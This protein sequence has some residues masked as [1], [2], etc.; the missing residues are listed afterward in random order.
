MF[1]KQPILTSVYDVIL[2][3]PLY[4]CIQL[5]DV[6]S[7]NECVNSVNI[8]NNNNRSVKGNTTAC[9]QS[10]IHDRAIIYFKS[11]KKS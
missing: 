2:M 11:G 1:K 6:A 8:S 3:T 4:C 10:E 9:I 5:L 7:T